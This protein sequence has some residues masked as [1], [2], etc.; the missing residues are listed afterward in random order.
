MILQL[1][2]KRSGAFC[3]ETGSIYLSWDAWNRWKIKA[4]KVE[5]KRG[6]SHISGK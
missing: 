1:V 4:Y 6:A 5:K 3:E 2:G